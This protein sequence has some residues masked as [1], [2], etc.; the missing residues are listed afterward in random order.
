MRAILPPCSPSWS[1]FV[2]LANTLH[3]VP[4]KL[5][6]VQAIAAVLRPAGLFAVVNWHSRPREETTVLSAERGPP[7]ELR[8]SPASTQDESR[9][10]TVGL[11]CLRHD[12]QI[13]SRPTP[14]QL[15]NLRPVGKL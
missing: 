11:A 7:T 2:L 5:A 14:G 8:M 13:R 15:E 12:R 4:D 9:A 1:I 10:R 3:G 6:L